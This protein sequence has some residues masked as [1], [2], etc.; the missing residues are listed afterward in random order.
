MFT[1]TGAN[2][3]VLPVIILTADACQL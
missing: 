3:I 1:T 2:T